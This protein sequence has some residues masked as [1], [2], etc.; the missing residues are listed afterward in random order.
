MRQFCQ[1]GAHSELQH[2]SG[3]PTLQL[4]ETEMAPRPPLSQRIG[5][6]NCKE[7]DLALDN[8]RPAPY[9]RS[10][11]QQRAGAEDLSM[12]FD[13]VCNQNASPASFTTYAMTEN[14]RRSR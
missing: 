12:S 13:S 1:L 10:D 8:S 6:A 9:M 14:P 2:V 4:D 5:K 11:V 3:A 7:F